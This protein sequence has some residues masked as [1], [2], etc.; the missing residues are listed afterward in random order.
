LLLV[1]VAAA[2]LTGSAPGPARTGLRAGAV[3]ASLA[4]WYERAAAQC[5]GLSPALLAA[6]GYQESDF[7]PQAVSPVG[8]A[9]IAQF[10]ADTWAIYGRDDDGSGHATRF[11]A[12]DA[13]MAQGRMMCRLLDKAAHSGI[14]GDPQVLALAG[15]NAGWGAVESHR[16]IPPYAETQGYVAHITGLA[17]HWTALTT[18]AQF[19]ALGRSG[20]R[21]S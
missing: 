17:R 1:A 18:D 14:P 13:I 10:T 3:P 20:L 19:A 6:Q 15:Y 9:G 4:S 21:G 7:N 5:P 11:N 16:G 2:A 12:H 8:A